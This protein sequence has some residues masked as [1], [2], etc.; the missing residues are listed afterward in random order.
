MFVR[1]FDASTDLVA[2]HAWLAAR[3]L[4]SELAADLPAVGFVVPDIACAFIRGVEGNCCIMDSLA[5]NP[6]A[7]AEARHAAL[8]MLF[9]AVRAGAQGRAIIGFTVDSGTL[10]RAEAH[11]F[12]KSDHILLV[13]KG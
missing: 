7:P 9:S 1:Q 8:E 2:V 6:E 3:G 10:M 4:S 5:S 12:K 13:H 11:G